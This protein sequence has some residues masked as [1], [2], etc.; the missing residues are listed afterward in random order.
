MALGVVGNSAVVAWGMAIAVNS[1]Q[2]AVAV[3]P[4][5][6]RG[7]SWGTAAVGPPPVGP[8]PTEGNRLAMAVLVCLA[9]GVLLGLGSRYGLV[10][11]A[12]AL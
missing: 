11:V 4:S 8:N 9:S 5:L 12:L 3:V 6:A 7:A 1:V 2:D 10:L